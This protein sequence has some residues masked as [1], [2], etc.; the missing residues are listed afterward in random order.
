MRIT[1]T[2]RLLIGVACLSLLVL[3][4]ALVASAQDTRGNSGKKIGYVTATGVQ[5]FTCVGKGV[6]E[7]LKNYGDSFVQAYS[8]GTAASELA[9]AQDV[10][11]QK[12]DALVLLSTNS[13]SGSAIVDLAHKA[14]IPIVLNTQDAFLHHDYSKVAGVVAWNFP[15]LGDA[16]GKLAAKLFPKGTKAASIEPLTGNVHSI[17]VGFRDAVV[18]AG[19][20][21]LGIYPAKDYDPTDV[22]KATQDLLT[23]HPDVQVIYIDDTGSV[24]AMFAAIKLAH[25]KAQV[26]PTGGRD[27]DKGLVKSGQLKGYTASPGYLIGQGSAML[28]NAVLNHQKLPHKIVYP[29]PPAVTKATLNQAPPFCAA[30]PFVTKYLQKV[31]GL[32]R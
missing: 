18:K 19:F 27:E 28:M 26:I 2:A 25:S 5:Y 17:D 10:L 1:R 4:V 14:G 11:A 16:T 32:K 21:W 30:S 9:A 22:Q 13:K 15:A 12:V 20:K 3:L 29:A 6:Q 31:T 8:T 23:A 7:T 24:A